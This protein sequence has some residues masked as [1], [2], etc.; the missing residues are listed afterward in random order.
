MFKKSL[1]QIFTQP[2]MVLPLFLCNLFSK[3]TLPVKREIGLDN[4]M[5]D[6]NSIIQTYSS[7]IMTGFLMFVLLIF[8]SPYLTAWTNL[9]VKDKAL[10]DNI[11][12][13]GSFKEASKYYLK[14]L[15]VSIALIMGL[16]IY[17]VAFLLIIISLFYVADNGSVGIFIMGII[18]FILILVFL[19]ILVTP[20]IPIL[21]V[22]NEGFTGAFKKSFKFG[23]SNFFNILGV[24]V[25]TFI[26][27]A[28]A[29]I[30]FTKVEFM[31]TIFNSYFSTLVTVYIIN[32][33]VEDKICCEVNR[34][35]IT[36]SNDGTLIE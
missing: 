14:V 24:F 2:L 10:K 13:K 19:S 28:I 15:V 21:V 25:F 27:I 7:E 22:D 8:I 35:E 36:I 4:G 12:F 26:I 31:Q 1:K 5:P 32:K 20:V 11:D 29:N 33:Y 23:L 34:S 6:L 16:I 30:I 18:F 3:I 17:V 9:M